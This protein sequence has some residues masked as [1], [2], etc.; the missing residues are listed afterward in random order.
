MENQIAFVIFDG[1][2]CAIAVLAMNFFHP[3]FLFKQSYTA[4]KAENMER[5]TEMA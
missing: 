5:E 4:F 2:M 3:G 1:V